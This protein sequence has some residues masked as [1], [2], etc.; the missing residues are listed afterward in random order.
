MASLRLILIKLRWVNF[1]KPMEHEG[2]NERASDNVLRGGCAFRFKQK[3]NFQHV[4]LL[5]SFDR[6]RCPMRLNGS[7]M[8]HLFVCFNDI[9]A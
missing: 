4:R 1:Q 7:Y 2:S 9:V 3:M 8:L 6:G 5:D